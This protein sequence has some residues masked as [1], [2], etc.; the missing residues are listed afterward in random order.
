L[1]NLIIPGF[2]RKYGKPVKDGLKKKALILLKISAFIFKKPILL[3]DKS[4]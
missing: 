4:R 2:M 3:K 1:I